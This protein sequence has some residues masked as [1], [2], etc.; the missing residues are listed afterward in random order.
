M[1]GFEV[2]F[3]D[4]VI[5]SSIDK[6]LLEVIFTCNTRDNNEC[7][8]IWGLTSF[9]QLRWYFSSIKFDKITVRIVDI[10]RNSE[11]IQEKNRF[12]N[13]EEILQ[14]YYDLKK[15]LEKDGLL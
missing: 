15:E 7:L 5:R 9:D 13:D 6:G 3:N 11:L 14:R 8:Y 12:K 4:E 2:R 1:L 10:S